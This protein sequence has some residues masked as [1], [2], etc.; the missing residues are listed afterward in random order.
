MSMPPEDPTRTTAPPRPRHPQ[1][2]DAE[3]VNRLRRRNDFVNRMRNRKLETTSTENHSSKTDWS[4]SEEDKNPEN[5]E[6]IW[7][8]AITEWGKAHGTAVKELWCFYDSN[9]GEM[10]QM[11][12]LDVWGIIILL[13]VVQYYNDR[14]HTKAMIS[15]CRIATGVWYAWSP[16]PSQGGAGA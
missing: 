1:S 9:V 4:R 16:T 14:L 2:Q 5:A 10:P 11:Q 12:P 13:R 8:R 15:V 7:M 6:T 3:G